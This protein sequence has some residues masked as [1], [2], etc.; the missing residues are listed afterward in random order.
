MTRGEKQRKRDNF[1]ISKF[2]LSGCNAILSM[3]GTGYVLKIAK[4]NSQRENQCVLVTKIS[5]GETEKNPQFAKMNSRKKFRATRYTH[6]VR[7]VSTINCHC[8]GSRFPC[9]GSRVICRCCC[10]SLIKIVRGHS[11]SLKSKEPS[12]FL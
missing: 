3:L 11:N 2:K 10:C 8:R 5:F 12:P 6:L 7:F 9:R 1:T 4:I